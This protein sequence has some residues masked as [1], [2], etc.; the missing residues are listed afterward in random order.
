MRRIIL[1]S[2]Y[3]LMALAVAGISGYLVVSFMVQKAPEVTVPD[4]TDLALSDALDKL[5]EAKLDLEV[6]DFTY[7]DLVKE[8]RVVIQRPRPGQVIKEG[9]AVGVVLSRGS[10]RYPVPEVVGKRLEEAAILISEAGLKYE[11]AATVSGGQVDEVVGVG[12]EPGT[13]L[14]P[15]ETVRLLVASGPK[16]ILL[17]MPKVEGM[18]RGEAESVLSSLGLI[19]E[20]IESVNLGDAQKVGSIIGQDP[21]PGYPVER[22]AAVALSAAGVN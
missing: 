22:G 1:F 4:I 6:R 11:V 17:R 20:R 14:S 9:R 12:R 10:K 5:Q 15:G 3:F 2:V 16:P 18:T 19:I 8:N 21:Q 13:R 7:S